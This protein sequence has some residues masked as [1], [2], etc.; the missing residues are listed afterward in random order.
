MLSTLEPRYQPPNRSRLSEELIPAMYENE[1]SKLYSELQ[2]SGAVSLTCD[3]WTSRATESFLTVTCHFINKNWELC[4]KIL[5]TDHFEGS[6]TG[7]KVG[8]ELRTMM[9]NWGISDKVEVITVDN[10]SN[11]TV[12]VEVSG[13]NLKLGCFAHT[14]NLA[15]NKA[16]GIPSLDKI[17]GKVRSVVTYFHKSNIATEI[18]KEKQV[19]LQ[20]PKHKLIMD[21]KTRWNSTYQLL[22][23]FLE[24]RPAILATL[25]DD[26]VKKADKSRIVSGLGDSEIQIC[27][28]FVFNMEVMLTAT[29]V[30]CEEKSPT[31]GLLLPLLNK[32][33]DHFKAKEDDSAFVKSLKNAVG[34][35]LLTRYTDLNLK[36]FLEEASALDPRT[37]NKACISEKTWDRIEDKMCILVVTEITVKSEITHS[38]KSDDI[39]H[40]SADPPALPVMLDES[41]KNADE[42]KE[43][44]AE[45]V[46]I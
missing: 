38:D 37:K 42:D 10:A 20:L 11:M 24:Q 28:E 22:T 13:A 17:L 34:S 2:S 40:T 25:L 29:L 31:A 9:I 1:K 43:D 3:G 7:Q 46:R 19:A 36:N 12:A 33:T 23:R 5:Q 15:S 14:L 27:E 39:P 44:A 6:H 45:E 18:L 4:S 41:K 26:R 8:F 16:L 30:L 32:L 35:N 21:C